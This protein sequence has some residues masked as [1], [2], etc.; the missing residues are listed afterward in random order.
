MIDVPVFRCSMCGSMSGAFSYIDGR[1]VCRQ[2]YALWLSRPESGTCKRCRYYRASVEYDGPGS[3]IK[4]GL[5]VR[6]EDKCADVF[7]RE[8]ILETMVR[9]ISS[10]IYEEVK[11]GG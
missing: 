6:E 4:Y 8:R 3:C 1:P 7:R 2:C 9:V 5:V 10:V 11:G